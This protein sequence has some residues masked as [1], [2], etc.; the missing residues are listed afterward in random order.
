MNQSYLKKGKDHC[1]QKM[2]TFLIE[3]LS[4]RE[5]SERKSFIRSFVKRITVNY[6]ELELEYTFPLPTKAKD[7]T[8]T[9][10]VLSLNAL[11]DT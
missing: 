7:R 6:P 1:N 8:S 3:T 4:L 10:E 9:S 5:I 2:M 11:P